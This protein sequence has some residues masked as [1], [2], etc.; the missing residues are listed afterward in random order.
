VSDDKRT[1]ASAHNRIDGL[2]MGVLELRTEQRI[3][4][5]D[6]YNRVKRT[7]QILWAAA[8]SIIGLLIAVLMKVG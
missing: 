6:L 5:K 3:Q 4:F 2:E 8:G 1:V 7:E